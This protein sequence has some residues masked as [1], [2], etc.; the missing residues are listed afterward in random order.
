MF[1][2]IF[3]LFGDKNQCFFKNET[4]IKEEFEMLNDEPDINSLDR[5]SNWRHHVC[6]NSDTTQGKS[7]KW[8]I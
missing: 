6:S 8:I 3:R 2:N 7:F 5:D 4:Q 1:E